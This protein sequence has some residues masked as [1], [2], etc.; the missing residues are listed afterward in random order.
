[1]DTKS[2][3]DLLQ[4]IADNTSDWYDAVATGHDVPDRIILMSSLL[5]AQKRVFLG[6]KLKERP[7]AA[8]LEFLEWCFAYDSLFM[9][10]RELGVVVRDPPKGEDA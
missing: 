1:M 10:G 7:H 6:R 8:R 4:L 5:N 2:G 3:F 9:R